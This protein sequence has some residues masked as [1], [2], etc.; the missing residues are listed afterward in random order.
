MIRTS[1]AVPAV[2]ALLV[3]SAPAS[4]QQTYTE[5][6][7]NP[8]VGSRWTIVSETNATEQRAAGDERS[9]Q[10]YMRSELTI[11]EKLAGGYR[12]SYVS[13]DIKVSGNTAGARVVG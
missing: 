13:R 11:D 7:Y 9:Q 10:T 8:P 6:L 1:R 5:K 12:I 3:L 4:A 2:V